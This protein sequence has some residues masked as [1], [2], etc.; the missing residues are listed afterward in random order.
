VGVLVA[1]DLSGLENFAAWVL[2]YEIVVS[3]SSIPKGKTSRSGKKDK[4][5]TESHSSKRQVS[6]KYTNEA[7]NET[8]NSDYDAYCRVLRH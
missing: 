4:S 2:F 7:D 3:L 8:G 1:M 6:N 5:H